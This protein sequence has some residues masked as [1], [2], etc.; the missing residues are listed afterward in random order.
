MNI[1]RIIGAVI[2]SVGKV[3]S[4]VFVWLFNALLGVLKLSIMLFL[5]VFQIVLGIIGSCSRI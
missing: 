3:L 1:L 5:L 4:I 2:G